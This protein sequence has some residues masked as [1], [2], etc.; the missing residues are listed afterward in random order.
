MKRRITAMHIIFYLSIFYFQP[1]ITCPK[2]TIETLKKTFLKKTL[3]SLFIDGVQLP[4]F[5]FYHQVPKNSWYSLYR[6]WKGERLSRPWS[7]PVVLNTGPPDWESS[8]LRC[9]IYL[10]LKIKTPE[11]RQWR[12][13]GVFVVN[14]DIFHTLFQCFYC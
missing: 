14:L 3:R 4:Q 8:A 11:R 2:I 12:C 7:Q 13:S 6:P 10:K 1:S 5:T 9:E